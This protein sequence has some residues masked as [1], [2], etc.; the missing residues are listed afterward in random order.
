M[1]TNTT[2]YMRNYYNKNKQNV[3]YWSYTNE[4]YIKNSE[5]IRGAQIK[6]NGKKVQS[7]SNWNRRKIPCISDLNNVFEIYWNT[8]NCVDCNKDFLIQDGRA[9]CM[10]QDPDTH[11]FVSVLCKS[12]SNNRNK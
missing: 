10:Y 1:P 7:I 4:N 9:K 8:N 3:N 2:A 12:C 11:L 6:Y 5:R